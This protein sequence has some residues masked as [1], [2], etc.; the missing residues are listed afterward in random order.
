MNN[1]MIFQMVKGCTQQIIKIEF[2]GF[3][4]AKIEWIMVIEK[5]PKIELAKISKKQVEPMTTRALPK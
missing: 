3:K 4:L 5:H 1:M 2:K